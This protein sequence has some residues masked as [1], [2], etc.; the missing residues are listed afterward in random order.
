MLMGIMMPTFLNADAL[1]DKYKDFM[2]KSLP[3]T[4]L[5]ANKQVKKNIVHQP[6]VTEEERW[7]KKDEYTTFVDRDNQ[8]GFVVR[9]I[10]RFSSWIKSYS[11][12]TIFESI[13]ALLMYSTI[14][15]FPFILAL[16]SEVSM[17]SSYRRKGLIKLGIYSGPDA[18][19]SHSI[20]IKIIHFAYITI[21][22]L[23]LLPLIINNLIIYWN[24]MAIFGFI[25]DPMI[26]WFK[27]LFA[28][29]GWYI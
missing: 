3:D 27:A 19:S 29:F 7:V 5:N 20:S 16:Y 1:E 17:D 9:N 4:A 26:L 11:A 10:N 6:K 13:L 18:Y 22:T 24:P 8:E 15:L 23:F 28:I 25:W 2:N 12:G 14:I 21:A